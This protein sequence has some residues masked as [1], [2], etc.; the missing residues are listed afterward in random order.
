MSRDTEERRELQGCLII[1]IPAYVADANVQLE[2]L[3]K[4]HLL[5][6]S[7][8]CDVEVH[9][10]GGLLRHWARCGKRGGCTNPWR[11]GTACA[12]TRR[13]QREKRD[14]D[15]RQNGADY[16]KCAPGLTEKWSYV[17]ESESNNMS[18]NASWISSPSYA[19]KMGNWGSYEVT[20]KKQK[21]LSLRPRPP[22]SSY[23]AANDRRRTAS[24]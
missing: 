9:G 19:L 15:N 1:P 24:C 11:P 22:L 17:L 8:R 14:L 21:S 5:R 16:R 6:P 20:A 4:M 23:S 10:A 2:K 12:R 3:W 18:L 7:N 13:R